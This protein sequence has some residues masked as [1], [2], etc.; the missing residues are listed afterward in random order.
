MRLWWALHGWRGIARALLYVPLV[1]GLFIAFSHF[2][3]GVSALWLSVGWTL[4]W[5][6]CLWLNR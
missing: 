6:A 5:F 1:V 3:T 4:C 2:D